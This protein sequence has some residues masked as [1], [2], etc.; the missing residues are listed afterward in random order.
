[1]QKVDIYLRESQEAPW[2]V[3]MLDSSREPQDDR[4]IVAMKATEQEAQDWA[5]EQETT[6]TLRYIII[7]D[8]NLQRIGD[9]FKNFQGINFENI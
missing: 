2:K 5:T 3:V 1:M 6:E 9:R 4:I 8:T 7:E